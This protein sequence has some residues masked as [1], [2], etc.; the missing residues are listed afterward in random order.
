MSLTGQHCNFLHLNLANMT[1]CI[2]DHK[3]QATAP[4]D[5]KGNLTSAG[6][7]HSAAWSAPVLLHQRICRLAKQPSLSIYM[8]LT[9]CAASQI[10]DAAPSALHV[11]LT[12]EV[13]QLTSAGTLPAVPLLSPKKTVCSP[14]AA[15][16][17]LSCYA[18]P[19]GQHLHNAQA[20]MC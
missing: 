8:T 10:L 12:N 11:G 19:S 15:W 2:G 3:Q 14:A 7:F 9:L 18:I 17:L 4:T 20:H 6:V 13:Y 5:N 16:H 1:V